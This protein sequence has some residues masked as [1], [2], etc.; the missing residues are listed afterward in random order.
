MVRQTP[1]SAE[2]AADFFLN[3]RPGTICDGSIVCV[4]SICR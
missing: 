4:D 2:F 1:R 3:I